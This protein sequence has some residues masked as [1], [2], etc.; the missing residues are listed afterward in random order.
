MTFNHLTPGVK[1]LGQ[2]STDKN[3]QSDN[4]TALLIHG[5]VQQG[6]NRRETVFRGEAWEGR[7]LKQN[8]VESY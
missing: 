2:K 5:Q 8:Y 1:V 7:N 6:I 4:I 3:P